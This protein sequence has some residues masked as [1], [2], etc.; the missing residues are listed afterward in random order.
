MILTIATVVYNG[1]AE[2]ENTILSVIPLRNKDIEY[3]IIDG[4]SKDD[5]LSIIDK[6]HDHI[7]FFL[8]ESDKGIYDAMNKAVKSARGK[9]IYILNAGDLLLGKTFKMLFEE[10]LFGGR[11]DV[12]YGDVINKQ[13]GILIKSKEINK[14]KYLLP[15]CHQGVIVK[16][17]LYDKFSFLIKYDIAADYD[18]LFK[19]YNFGASFY[20]INYPLAYYD[21]QGISTKNSMHVYKQ[22]YNIIFNNNKGFTKIIGALLY[23]G[24]HIKY[25]CYLMINFVLGERFY[26]KLRSFFK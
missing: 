23:T 17:E 1:A 26:R 4:N 14:I 19:S 7:D 5:T 13:S 3:I 8:T 11:Y 25:Y 15:V 18:M 21:M 6:Y 20:K 16:K 2:I 10:N 9:Y 22:Y 12:L 24:V